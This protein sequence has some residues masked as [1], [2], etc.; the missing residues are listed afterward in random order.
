LTEGIFDFFPQVMVEVEAEVG[1]GEGVTTRQEGQE[2]TAAVAAVDTTAE[3]TAEDTA[4]K[5]IKIRFSLP[6]SPHRFCT[7]I[8]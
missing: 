8:M 6:I 4:T 5:D 3:D 7:C 1:M 2:D